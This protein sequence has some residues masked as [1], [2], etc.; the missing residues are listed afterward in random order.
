[1]PHE[2]IHVHTCVHH[3]IYSYT[4][5]RA[6]PLFRGC[7]QWFPKAHIWPPHQ[8]PSILLH[9]PESSQKLLS[10]LTRKIQTPFLPMQQAS[11]AGVQS[12]FWLYPE[13]ST[14][15]THAKNLIS[16]LRPKEGELGLPHPQLP[17]ALDGIRASLLLVIV[18]GETHQQAQ[19]VGNPAVNER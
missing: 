14:P 13:L 6:Q 18:P 2:C 9:P 19:G 16:I 5:Y 7:P 17:L 4:Q 12:C 15:E 11:Q 1:M 10:F 3:C 8:G